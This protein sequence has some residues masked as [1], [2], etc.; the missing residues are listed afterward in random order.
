MRR[1]NRS[2]SSCERRCGFAEEDILDLFEFTG[3]F[4]VMPEDEDFEVYDSANEDYDSFD[5]DYDSYD[6]DEEAVE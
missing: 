2:I 4:S 6:E 1:C 3:G 5:E